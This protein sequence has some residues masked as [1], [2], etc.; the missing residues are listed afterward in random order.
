M[1]ARIPDAV[2]DAAARKGMI[3]VWERLCADPQL[4]GLPF[5]FETTLAGQIIMSPA[6]MRHASLQGE[7]VGVL[8]TLARESGVG[9]KVMCECPV[10]TADGV[11][12]PDV[13]WLSRRQ[14]DAF[15]GETAAPEAP[16]VCVEVKS[17]SNLKKEMDTKKSLYFAA[18][19]KE[20]WFCD[21]RGAM[22][23]WN[24]T[25]RLKRSKVFATFPTLVEPL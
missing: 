18:G 7:I 17:P 22:T 9:G 20:V 21:D 4:A 13:A 11:K 19:A 24:A 23:F 6:N 10:V 12:V 1:G 14:V 25:G 8:H 5:K 16:A 2:A 15:A 3:A